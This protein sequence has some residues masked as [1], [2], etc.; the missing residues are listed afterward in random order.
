MRDDIERVKVRM[1][2]IVISI[3]VCLKA[4]VANSLRKI[5]VHKVS[6]TWLSILK[7]TLICSEEGAMYVEVN[8]DYRMPRK[9]CQCGSAIVSFWG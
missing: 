8:G 2:R 7:S 4:A 5:D 1:K 6:T 9:T 3:K